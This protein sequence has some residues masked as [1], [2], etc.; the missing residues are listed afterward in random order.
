MRAAVCHEFGRPLA[1]EAVD[2]APP[3]PGEIEVRLAACAICHSD[4]HFIDGDWSR[5]LPAVYGHEAA[6]VIETVGPGVED[7]VPG[8]HAV[9]TLVRAC[10]RCPECSSGRPVL[11]QVRFP[12][13]E[14]TPL[15]LARDGRAV[16][17]GLR[18]GAFAE[19]VVVH[20]SQAVAIDPAVP[21]ECAALLACGVITGVGA[22]VHTA[23]VRP[24]ESVA[25]IG[26]GGVGLNAVQGA[27]L[28][29]AGSIVAV[30]VAE[31]KLA[32]ARELGA[33]ATVLAPVDEPVAAVRDLSG[34]RGVDYAF[35]TVGIGTAVEQ[36]VA[37]LAPGGAAVLVGMPANG[38]T[39]RIEPGE[40]AGAGRRL[41]GSKMG[42]ARIRA[43]VP[44]L[45]DLY[46]QGRLRLDELITGRYPLE[47]INE[48]ITVARSGEARRNVIVF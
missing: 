15:T 30:D 2:L 14:R 42:G 35:V 6:G 29:G 23:R 17:Q 38:I 12:L 45:V 10:G 25:V 31:S 13:D 9:V 48:A 7:L 26:A 43:D 32:A 47:A 20:A 39:A 36:A 4:I 24:G 28:A 19:R 34:G 46:R 8:D 11:C 41:L 3:G 5:N 37:M 22:V 16:H 21:L 1:V 40:L 18:T 27:R 44:W 33:T